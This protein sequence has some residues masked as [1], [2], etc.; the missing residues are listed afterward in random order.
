[1][2]DAPQSGTL[3]PIVVLNATSKPDDTIIEPSL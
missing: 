2:H 3:Q 1:M